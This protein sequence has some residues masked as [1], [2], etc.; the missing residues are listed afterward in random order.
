MNREILFR[1]FNAD[2]N[3]WVFG[4]L[5]VKSDKTYEIVDENKNHMQVVPESVGQFIGLIDLNGTKIFEGDIFKFNDETWDSIFTDCGYEYSSYDVINYGVV[6][7][8]EHNA[9]FDFIQYKI[10]CNSVEADLHENHDLEFADFITDLT[11]V[12][13]IFN[14]PELMQLDN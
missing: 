14:N 9:R 5:V 6:G 4:N 7:Y 13:N 10:L 12:G 11:I 3:S 2:T 8:D 1:G